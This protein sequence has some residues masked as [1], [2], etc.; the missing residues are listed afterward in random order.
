V[1]EP[2]TDMAYIGEKY[3]RTHSFI[4]NADTRILI[5]GTMEDIYNEVKRCMDIGKKCPGFFMAIGNHLSPNTPVEKA[6][7][8]NDVYEKMGR[9]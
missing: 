7:Y 1:M 9:R 4:G 5:Y 8:Y 6:L 2:S 3:G